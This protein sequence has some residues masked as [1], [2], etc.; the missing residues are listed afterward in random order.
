MT[1]GDEANDPPPWRTTATRDVYRNPWMTVREHDVVRPDG[2]SGIYGVVTLAGAAGVLPFVDDDH[3]LLV[4]QRRYITGQVSWEMPTGGIDPGEAPADAARRELAEE[5]GHRAER[6][7]HLN[8]HTT[9]K[10]VVDEWAHLFVAEGLT[11]LDDHEAAELETD[12]TEVIERR[13][14]PWHQLV[15]WVLDGTVVDSMTIVAVLLVERER[16]DRGR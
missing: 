13:V 5:T 12:E 14:V 10:S 8:T 2:S 1:I 6:L 7:R 11:P 3:V 4:R 16:R 15:G 9:S